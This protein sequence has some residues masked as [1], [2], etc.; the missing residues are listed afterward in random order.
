TGWTIAARDERRFLAS[1]RDVAFDLV[2]VFFADERSHLGF[3]I[4]R[5]S[6]A[7]SRC[8]VLHASD[9]LLKKILLNENSRAGRADLALVDKDAEKRA[10]NGRVEIGIGKEDVR[11]F[12]SKLERH[13]FQIRIGNTAQNVAAGFGSACECN[14]VD[15][16]R[17]DNRA[18]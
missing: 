11:R 6:K 12:A 10:I 18:P 8:Q 2:E 4:E 7:D 16:H 1:H 15:V 9:E 14:L 5:I 3:A 17:F 13:F